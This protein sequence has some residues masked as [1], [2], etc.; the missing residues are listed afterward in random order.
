MELLDNGL[1]GNE[2]TL[3]RT[4]RTFKAYA[5]IKFNNKEWTV[6][7]TYIEVDYG[8]DYSGAGGVTRSLDEVELDDI[9]CENELVTSHGFV[10]FGN[11]ISEMLKSGELGKL[12]KIEV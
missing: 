1:D 5:T 3:L 6:P 12:L 4:A 8:E 7:Y 9:E 10:A 2:V 11:Q